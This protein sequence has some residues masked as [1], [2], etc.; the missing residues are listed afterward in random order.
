M[1]TGLDS[2]WDS[3]NDLRSVVTDV[4]LERL[5]SNPGFKIINVIVQLNLQ[6]LSM[7]P[8]AMDSMGCIEGDHRKSHTGRPVHPH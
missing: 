6:C 8:P 1:S 7:I 2:E 3:T 5:D 4:D